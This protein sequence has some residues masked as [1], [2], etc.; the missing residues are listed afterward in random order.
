MEKQ[1]GEEPGL[2]TINFTKLV[3]TLEE[4][5]IKIPTVMT[6][7]NSIGYQMNPSKKE[8]ENFLPKTNVIAMNV[9]A[10]GYLK[11]MEAFDYISKIGINS[12]VVGM[13]SK[14]HAQETIDVFN[15]YNEV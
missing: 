13:S 9:L 7:F 8:C 14:E 15:R 3:K 10:G 4:W 5:S 1:Y 6:S 2:V 12:V 11:P